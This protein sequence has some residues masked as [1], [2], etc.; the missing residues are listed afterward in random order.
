[1]PP[2]SRLLVA[3]YPQVDEETITKYLAMNSHIIYALKT[4]SNSTITFKRYTD[5]RAFPA[6]HK[7]SNRAHG[8]SQT[9]FVALKVELYIGNEK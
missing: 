5:G 8:I 9:K 1:M 6:F 2:I 7:I 4:D 3:S